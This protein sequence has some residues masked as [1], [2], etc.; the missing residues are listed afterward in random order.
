MAIPVRVVF[1]DEGA[2]AKLLANMIEVDDGEIVVD[3][4]LRLRPFPPESIS[5]LRDEFPELFE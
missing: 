1:Y 5:F 2:E 4:R 3:R